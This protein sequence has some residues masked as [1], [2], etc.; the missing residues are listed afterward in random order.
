MRQSSSRLA[1][2]PP[3][4]SGGKA[5]GGSRSEGS[6]RAPFLGLASVRTYLQAFGERLNVCSSDEIDIVKRDTYQ[7]CLVFPSMGNTSVLCQAF[8]RGEHMRGCFLGQTYVCRL[9]RTELSKSSTLTKCLDDPH[10]LSRR[11]SMLLVPKESNFFW[12]KSSARRAFGGCLGS[13][14]R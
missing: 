7:H 12:I 1:V 9:K 14:R 2:A 4:L 8:G 6:M 13:K 5:S 3:S 10:G 11:E